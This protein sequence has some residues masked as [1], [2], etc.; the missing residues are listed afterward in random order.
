MHTL[1][2]NAHVVE[3]K[4]FVVDAEDLVLGRLSSRVASVLRGKHKAVFTPHADTGDFV[5]VINAEKIRVTGSKEQQK[6]Y[7]H[8]TGFP[9]GERSVTVEKQ[10]IEHP[11]R[12]I[13]HA[14]KGML[15]KG[16]LGRKMIK[17]LKVYAGEAHPHA[18]QKP[19]ALKI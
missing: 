7:W 16:P 15:P 8:Y 17:K 19:E 1:S 9:G 11:D 4:W 18:A 6:K 14:V 2:S 13:M 12:I 5:V 3:R 10:R